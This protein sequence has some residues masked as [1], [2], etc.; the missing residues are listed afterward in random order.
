[1]PDGSKW[2]VPAE[3]IAAHRAAYYSK[4]TDANDVDFKSE[5]AVAMYDEYELS[6]WAENNMNWSDVAT[7]AKRVESNPSEP[8]YQEGWVSGLKEVITV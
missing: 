4:T 6:D 3:V 5:F 1:M 2:D 7:H 8:D